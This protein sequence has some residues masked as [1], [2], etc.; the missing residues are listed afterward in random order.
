M[1]ISFSS[2]EQVTLG[3]ARRCMDWIEDVTHVIAIVDSKCMSWLGGA[4]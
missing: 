2:L 3:K 1:D 4:G